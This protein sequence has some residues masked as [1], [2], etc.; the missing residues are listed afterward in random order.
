MKAFRRKLLVI[1]HDSELNKIRGT[2]V[3]H[4][5]KDE[6]NGSDSD[7]IFLPSLEEKHTQDVANENNPLSIGMASD[8]PHE[9]VEEICKYIMS[10]DDAECLE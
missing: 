3:Y 5:S 4:Q 1:L 7:V 8:E 10:I 9:L 6:G 2:P